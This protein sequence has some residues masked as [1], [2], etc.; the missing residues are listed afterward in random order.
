M[1]E[2]DLREELRSLSDRGF[3]GVECVVLA[4]GDAIVRSEDGWG[5]EKWNHMVE[6]INDEAE[7][8]G[9]SVDLTIGPAWPIASPVIKN[10]DDPAA[11]RE[12]TWGEIDVQGDY[13]GPLPARRTVRDEGTP[14]LVAVMAYKA[15]GEG[16]LVQDNY[17][18]L[19]ANVAGD[20]LSCCLPEGKW[21]IFAFW[22]QPAVQKINAGQTY[23]IDH[24]GKAGAQA[25]AEY[26]KGVFADSKLSAME[27]LFCDSLEYKVAQEWT[28]GLD[29]IFL[30]K[31]GYSL[32]P[33]LPVVG[34]ANS[35]PAG[36]IPGYKFEDKTLTDM[37]NADFCEVLTQCYCENHLVPLDRMAASYGK[38]LRYQVAYN[39]PFEVER[40]GLYV[41]LPE[42]EALGRSSIDGQK[43]MAA[44]AHLGRKPRY[45]FECAAEF[46]HSYG[47]DYEDLFWWIKRGLMAGM[48][49][50]VLHGAS[51][52]GKT[53][54]PGVKWPGYEGFGKFVS[55]Y[56]NR[57]PDP[58]HARGC[59]DAITR[60]NAVFRKRAKVDCAI[61]RAQY[62]S[63][64]LIGE[65]GFY[66]DGGKLSNRGYSYEFVSESLLKLP[67]CTVQ[68]GFLDRDGVGYKC[69]IIPGHEK[70]STAFLHTVR[71]LLDEGLRIVWTGEKP[72]AGK[73]YSDVNTP[74]KH[75]E[76]NAALA[77]VWNDE[78]VTR[79]AV[80]EDVP[81][82]LM[83]IGIL[84]DVLLDGG[85]TAATAV[86]L[87]GK[88][89]YYAVYAHN[90]LIHIPDP[91]T[92]AAQYAP[93]TAKGSYVRP[94]VASRGMMDVSIVGEGK[95]SIMEPWSGRIYDA[96]FTK[97]GTGRM[98]GRI[99]IEEDELVILCL[100]E[101]AENSAAEYAESN[102][103]PVQ[104]ETAAFSP[105]RADSDGETSFLRS[106][107]APADK[108]M[109][110]HEPAPWHELDTSLRH[111]G[112]KCEYKGMFVVPDTDS[113]SRY[114]L[115]LGYVC[116]TFTVQVNGQE[117]PF[118]DQV[119]KRT[120]ITGLVKKGENTVRITVVSN[121]Y[122]AV[123]P[124]ESITHGHKFT[125]MPR[126]YGIWQDDNH[127][128]GV[129][130]MRR[131]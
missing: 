84:P 16:T 129:R 26:W 92:P 19:T 91:T 31:R 123:M 13:D 39:K 8:L 37:I 35:F 83:R 70:L 40:C 112:G 47:Q 55:N 11:L 71:R 89:R 116:D 76:W 9:M 33:F 80:I 48:N 29:K 74:E 77:A 124:D 17:T 127:R 60:M 62:S 38:T 32:I 100:E 46:G 44:A 23:T 121:L 114:L 85:R 21:K 52:S 119:M 86:R 43:A 36:D 41:A 131:I 45:S 126:K 113:E 3:G 28:P 18:D 122:N 88:S 101:G 94:G 54:A 106:S 107:F 96:A 15:A 104:F 34:M 58:V 95:V 78:K 79:T 128:I 5:T 24:L 111:F 90:C 130:V 42:N 49:A 98:Q 120:D 69:L 75:A 87:D 20:R 27:S 93:G 53:T 73:F 12:L 7:K 25:V 64:G 4:F 115:E 66:P 105:F 125:F 57:T 81:A 51:Y 14:A 1:D 117:A 6:I 97:D 63:D 118:P 65:Y 56:W 67:V 72:A 59:M 110:L 109:E 82:A 102:I 10:A 68:D 61:Y 2:A 50:Q 103:L 30:E 22:E 108:R 99:E